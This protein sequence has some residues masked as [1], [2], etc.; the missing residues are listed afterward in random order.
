MSGMGPTT[1]VL[2]LLAGDPAGWA[3]RRLPRLVIAPLRMPVLESEGPRVLVTLAGAPQWS[4]PVDLHP[5][6]GVWEHLRDDGTWEVCHHEFRGGERE[7]ATVRLEASGLL[8]PGESR[9]LEVIR[10]GCLE[11]RG[12]RRFTLRLHGG[13]NCCS[14][15][16]TLEVVLVPEGPADVRARWDFHNMTAHVDSVLAGYEFLRSGKRGY[17]DPVLSLQMGSY[18]SLEGH[19]LDESIE[20]ML[21]FLQN[22]PSFSYAQSL[23]LRLATELA[24]VGRTGDA[25]V[26][27]GQIT[28]TPQEP[29]VLEDARRLIAA[30]NAPDAGTVRPPP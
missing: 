17:D 23:R 26:Q 4:G 7:V 5:V 8:G 20:Q 6:T 28:G 21:T 2:A 13:S 30:I 18:Q 14:V 10:V 1:L 9:N 25:L 27:L 15:S 11:R 29:F 24:I 19:E 22:F 12:Q 3:E 16:N